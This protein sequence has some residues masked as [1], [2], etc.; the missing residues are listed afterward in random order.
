M[1]LF[2]KSNLS[3]LFDAKRAFSY[4]IKAMHGGL[5]GQEEKKKT[6]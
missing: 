2:Q 3:H 4:R 5:E 6:C 1:H